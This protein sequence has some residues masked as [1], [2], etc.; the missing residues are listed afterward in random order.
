M[1]F[2]ICA[3]KLHKLSYSYNPMECLSL[4]LKKGR[5]IKEHL[6]DNPNKEENVRNIYKIIRTGI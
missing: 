3:N 2:I 1:L 4:E 5:Y 6:E